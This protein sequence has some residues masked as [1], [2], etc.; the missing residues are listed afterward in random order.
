MNYM[1]YEKI[2]MPKKMKIWYYRILE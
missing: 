1:Y 2:F